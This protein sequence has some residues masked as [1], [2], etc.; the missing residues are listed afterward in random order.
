MAQ[1]LL[2]R[3]GLLVFI[4]LVFACE[5]TTPPAGPQSPPLD[6]LIET[7]IS[8]L[9]QVAIAKNRDAIIFG[10]HLQQAT[11]AFLKVPDSQSMGI[12]Q[13]TW[14]SAHQ[15]YIGSQIGLFAD[16]PA[17]SRLVF[18][19]D[20]W[21]VQPGFID[22]IQGYPESGIINDMTIEITVATL[23]RQHGITDSEEVCLGYHAIEYLVFQRPLDDFII[24]EPQPSPDSRVVRRRQLLKL[25]VAEIIQDLTEVA[26][27]ITMQFRK[28]KQRS[29]SYILLNFVSRTREYLQLAFRES[30]YLLSQS[31]SNRRHSLFS[32]TSVDSLD[33]E[34]KALKQ[35]TLDKVNLAPIFHALDEISA[36]NYEVTLSA[37]IGL[38]GDSDADDAARA[39]LPLMLSALLHQLE[40]FEVALQ[41]HIQTRARG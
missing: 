6:P 39:N 38:I 34:L 18:A 21:P 33:G 5:K 40:A 35:F 24:T 14:R 25:M 17:K 36:R 37:V 32:D 12:L 7:A 27:T 9:N 11:D 10:E 30:D 8:Q 4:C 31:S 26:D 2:K 3:P 16:S 23:R 22:D 41:G 19:L 13:A 29:N 1:H 28:G 20:S 15:A